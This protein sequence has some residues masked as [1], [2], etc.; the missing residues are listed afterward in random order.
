[1]TSDACGKRFMFSLHGDGNLR[2]WDLVDRCRIFSHCLSSPDFSDFGPRMLYV[3]E[4]N[5]NMTHMPVAVLYRSLSVCF[6]F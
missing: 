3:G 4:V 1:V 5:A 2:I 6:F